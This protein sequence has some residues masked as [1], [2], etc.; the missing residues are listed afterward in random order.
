VE[1]VRIVPAGLD[2]LDELVEFWIRLHQ[3]QGSLSDPVAGI[4]PRPGDEATAS[5][6]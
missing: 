2:R 3:H 6:R 5:E 1:E 4:E